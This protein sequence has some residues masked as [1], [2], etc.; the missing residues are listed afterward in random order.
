MEIYFIN[1]IIFAF[2]LYISFRIAKEIKKQI[3]V[4]KGSTKELIEEEKKIMKQIWKGVSKPTKT[5]QKK[6]LIE[7]MERLEKNYNKLLRYAL[8]IAIAPLTIIFILKTI[9]QEMTLIEIGGF[10]IKWYTLLLLLI[11]IMVIKVIIKIREKRNT[12]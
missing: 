1:I 6:N 4:Q 7:V 9:M 12:Q 11:P 3:G 5:D 2:T 10:E 8:A